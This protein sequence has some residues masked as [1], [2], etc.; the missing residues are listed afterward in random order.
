[1]MSQPASALHQAARTPVICVVRPGVTLSACSR[2][3]SPIGLLTTVALLTATAVPGIAQDAHPS[4]A[5]LAS[6]TRATYAL[7]TPGKFAAVVPGA[8][9]LRGRAP[10]HGQLYVADR[11]MVFRPDG[12]ADVISVPMIVTHADGRRPAWAMRAVAGR[13][14]GVTVFDIAGWGRFETTRPTAISQLLGG[15]SAPEMLSEVPGML[16]NG[17]ITPHSV[18]ADLAV[19]GFA[20]T[21]YGI[22][23]R[24]RAPIGLLSEA[25]RRAGDAA[26]YAPATDSIALDPFAARSMEDLRGMLAHE[27]GHRLQRNR[28]MLLDDVW[29]TVPAITDNDVYGFGNREEHQAEAFRFAVMYLRATASAARDREADILL[30]DLYESLMPGTRAVAGRLLAE[31]M[32]QKHPLRDRLGTSR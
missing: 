10:L 26:L 6:S 14:N 12:G 19:S 28:P 24:P 1:M 9:V 7:A 15:R 21:L 18:I 2:M 17:G 8:L 16:L 20:D 4:A 5:P 13:A 31:H 30:L 23:G 29:A 32:F 22:A 11:W 3:R 27:I 25:H